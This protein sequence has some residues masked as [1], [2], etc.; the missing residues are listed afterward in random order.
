M[1]QTTYTLDE[2]A[3]KIGI[4]VDEFKRRQREES[5]FKNLRS[6]RDGTTLR[7][8]ANEIDELARNLGVGSDSEGPIPVFGVTEMESR[9]E[10]RPMDG[11]TIIGPPISPV[12][13]PPMGTQLIPRMEMPEAPPVKPIVAKTEADIP[14]VFDDSDNFSLL[15]DEPP[16]KAPPSIKIPPSGP[17]DSDVALTK[18]KSTKTAKKEDVES[19]F[20]DDELQFNLAS[21][22]SKSGRIPGDKSGKLTSGKS[23]KLTTGSS[24]KM[25]QQAPPAA[26]PTLDR[27]RQ[28]RV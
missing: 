25:T 14:L 15:P 9:P 20:A 16:A 8:R 18:D 28:Q 10:P 21:P 13:P 24:P 6:F 3:A 27:R 19:I 1:A 22:S 12:P 2:A 7:F 4:S 11:G 26:A 23:G 5:A 17:L